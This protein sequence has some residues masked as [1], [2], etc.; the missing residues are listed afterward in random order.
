MKQG[1]VW[2]LGTH[3]LMCGDATKKEDVQKLLRGGAVDRL[4]I[5]RSAL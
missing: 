5:N 4:T 3:Y 1:Q 2:K